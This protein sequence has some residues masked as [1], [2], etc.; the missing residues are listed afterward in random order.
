M[1][2]NKKER[3]YLRML[4]KQQLEIANL[5][6]MDETV[7]RWY[8]HNDLKLDVPMIVIDETSFWRDICPN[9]ICHNILA[10]EIE[11]QLLKNI[12]P[13]QLFND[14]KI[15]PNYYPLEFEIESLR[16]GFSPHRICSFNYQDIQI[17]P[18]LISLKN[19]FYKLSFSKYKINYKSINTKKQQ[20]QN[21]LGD[22]L[23]VVPI[24]VTN[25]WNCNIVYQ[26]LLL[27]GKDNLFYA[28]AKE[29]NEFKDLMTFL[30]NDT[31]HMLKFQEYEH[32]INSHNQNNY[33]GGGSYCFTNDLPNQIDKIKTMDTWGYVDAQEVS[34]VSAKVFREFILPE[35]KRI[36]Q[37]FGLVYYG[38]REPIS[39]F[40]GDSIEN[41]PNLRKVSISPAC[42]ENF[43]APR[44]AEREIIY[45]RKPSPE[46][47]GSEKYF[48]EEAFRQHIKTSMEIIRKNNVHAEFIFR[49]IYKLHGNLDKLKRAVEIVREESNY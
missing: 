36:A 43:I 20:I 4:A 40:W 16:Y 2:I 28:L 10:R 41:I 31:I 11:E 21:I 23:D 33:I 24:N 13:Y 26:A 39:N 17:K 15:V 42:D 7:K 35:T 3:E 19:D 8:A 1:R 5:S 29:P 48:D 12:I 14:D 47:I 44:L 30:A 49:D 22:I 34:G 6:T 25:R 27:L 9:L 46:F 38:S 32:C 37:E 18:H 45:S